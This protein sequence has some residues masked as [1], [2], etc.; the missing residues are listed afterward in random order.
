MTIA[1]KD[2]GSDGE[3]NRVYPSFDLFIDDGTSTAD[4]RYEDPSRPPDGN[5]LQIK[6]TRH[7]AAGGLDLIVDIAGVRGP[8]VE[9]WNA[10]HPDDPIGAMRGGVMYGTG[11]F[12]SFVKHAEAAARS[13]QFMAIIYENV[14]NKWLWEVL[15]R[16]GYRRVAGD[17]FRKI[18]KLRPIPQGSSERSFYKG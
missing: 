1:L 4:V 13:R 15:A 6:V 3:D 12:R 16:Y 10:R 5:W 7:E 8:A 18:L 11:L 9:Q 17:N 2:N 14:G